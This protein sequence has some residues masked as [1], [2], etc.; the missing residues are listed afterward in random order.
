MK[1]VLTEALT[2]DALARLT[3]ANRVFAAAYPG[4]PID[5]QPVHTVYGGAQLFTHD[6]APKLGAAG[7]KGLSEY[8]PDFCT[9]ARAIGLSGAERL[10][11][12]PADRAALEARLAADP[13]AVR[14]ADPAAW[15]A[16][17]V[18]QRVLEKMKRE[19]IEDF[20]IDFEDGYGNRLDAEEDGHA[21][22]DAEQVAL[23]MERGTL[24]PFLGIRIKPFTEELRA[25]GIRTLDLF[26]GTLLPR[27]NGKLPANFVV[28]LP[29]VTIPEQV[30]TL[31]KLFE[32]LE[33]EHGL[34]P[35]TLRCEIM[36]ETTQSVIGPDG[37][38]PLRRLVAAAGGRIVGA[39]LGVYDYTASCNITALYQ[40]PGHPA[41]AFAR[42]VMQVA[43]AGTG[44]AISDGAV[45][46]M[47]VAPHRAAEG[48]TLTA[49]QAE[50]NRK[51]V[52]G[53]WRTHYD[54]VRRALREAYYQGWDLHPGQLP[55]RHAA[56]VAFFLEGR[57]EAAER[58]QRF[59]EKAAQATLLGNVFDDAATGQGLLNFFLRGISCGALTEAEALATGLTLDELRGR[60]F[61]KI[62][63]GRRGQA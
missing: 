11:G 37:V 12:L 52:H 28:T 38:V 10:P 62:L 14:K 45:T 39:H 40:A 48:G 19:P 22:A 6:I 20:R 3:A 29:K 42:H 63:K 5:R 55:T 60:S 23:G 32:V 17:T 4:D 24:P 9:F 54:E 59:V 44:V 35:G 16:H 47:P 25:R 26:L 49:V 7:L 56:V 51:A 43:L 18:Y 31:V 8:A 46:I 13:E 36:V 57:D 1:T 50:A 34:A 41:C 21:V 2:H 53:A 27:T 33:R 58:L 30:E 61:V 15:R